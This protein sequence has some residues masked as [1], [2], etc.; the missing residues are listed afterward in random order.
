MKYDNDQHNQNLGTLNYDIISM[1]I[2]VIIKIMI[3]AD[4]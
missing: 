1:N 3:W 2:I 4:I